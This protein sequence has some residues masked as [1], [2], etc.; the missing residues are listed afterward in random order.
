MSGEDCVVSFLVT[1]CVW[2]IGCALHGALVIV[3]FVYY[4][5]SIVYR[6]CRILWQIHCRDIRQA[7]YCHRCLTLYVHKAM[8]DLPQVWWE[9]LQRLSRSAGY[10]QQPTY[11][12]NIRERQFIINV[13]TTRRE[14][15]CGIITLYS[16]K[17]LC[18]FRDSRNLTIEAQRVQMSVE[19]YLV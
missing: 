19:K 16:V 11:R 4:F 9:Q 15:H 5:G 13:S 10:I 2:E 6:D 14:L 17:K 8:N 1:L 7:L 12:R 18:E 3:T